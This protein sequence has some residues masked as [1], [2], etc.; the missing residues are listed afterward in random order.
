MQK[1]DN[2]VNSLVSEL[3]WALQFS[4]LQGEQGD[5]GESGYK[6]LMGEPSDEIPGEDVSISSYYP[7]HKK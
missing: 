2:D 6:G 1:C 5:E 7:H 4:W 3:H